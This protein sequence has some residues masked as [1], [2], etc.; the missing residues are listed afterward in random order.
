MKGFQLAGGGNVVM[1]DVEGVQIGGVW[2]LA[3][4]VHHGIQ[5]SGGFNGAKTSYGSQIAGVHNLS[6]NEVAVQITGGVNIAKVVKGA[7]L[8][9]VLNVSRKEVVSQLAGGINI[10]K[11]VKGV[12][13]AGVLNIADSSDYP[14]AL[15]SLV[16]NGTK[17]LSVHIDDS[18]LVALNFRSGGACP[19]QRTWFW[20]ICR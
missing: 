17:Q 4:T 12:Q 15:L 3:D 18:K 5:L 1:N 9:G 13:L 7:Q 11:K 8:A 2:N 10:A 20:F 16:K 14:I 6:R 19:V